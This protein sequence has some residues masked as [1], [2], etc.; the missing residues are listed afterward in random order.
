MATKYATAKEAI[1]AK[2]AINTPS[3]TPTTPVT[4]TAPAPIA[5]PTTPTTPTTPTAPTPPR[6]EGQWNYGTADNQVLGEK[7]TVAPTQPTPT[8]KPASA[9]Q[10]IAQ[11][12]KQE[13]KPVAKGANAP[14]TT[15]IGREAKLGQL[16]IVQQAQNQ[17][18]QDRINTQNLKSSSGQQLWSN[19][20]TISKNNPSLLSSR[21][22]YDKAF[23]YQGKDAG[24]KALVD[25]YW[26]AKK[27]DSN[28]IYNS[29]ATGQK[30][31]VG[32]K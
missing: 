16:P 4:P 19:L 13:I 28:A 26:N 14:L 20:D 11:G 17:A 29:L 27:N 30:L 21:D 22:A 3:P 25:A 2:N 24:E 23:G 8:V 7:P 31:P 32:I 15:E 5:S 6:V 10:A 18:E 9:S 1:D 12:F